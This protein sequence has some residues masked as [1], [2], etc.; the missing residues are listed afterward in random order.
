MTSQ[1]LKSLNTNTLQGFTAQR[2]H[3]WHYK[4]SEQGT[5]PN[6]YDGAIPVGD[7]LRRLFGWHAVSAP[8]Q[9]VVPATFE[10]AT[11]LDAAGNPIRTV[12]FAGK[13]GI[14]RSDTGAPLGLHSK[15]YAIH[16]YDEW[17]VNNVSTILGDTLQIGSAGLL[18]GGAKAWVQIEAP[19]T[20]ATPEG[21][22]FRPHLMA[23][24]AHDGTIATTYMTGM[25]VVVCD[26][27]RAMALAEGKR[28]GQLIRFKHSS[29]SQLRLAEARTA[30]NVVE[31][32]AD[33]FTAEVAALCA[34]PVK[35]KEW[36][37]FLDVVA[38]LPEQ[39]GRSR[40][41][42]ENKRDALN[43][44]WTNDM[45]VAPWKGTA[46]GVVQAMNTYE[47]HEKS[48]RGGTRAD[49]NMHRAITGGVAKLDVGTL[50]TLRIVQAQL[51]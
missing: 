5:E 19:E 4:A 22:D 41:M 6:H 14:V 26:N 43:R 36:Q 9:L 24:T 42:A 18:D 7:V 31:Q 44:L 49:R 2:G 27:T 15:G 37:G 32:I 35:P 40:T 45:R 21:V 28:N 12:E 20:I 39:A 30:L 3:A 34:E 16:Q 29:G 1:T 11:G 38:K 50:E 17:L 13:Q 51:A 8:V 25:T 23:T 48:V 33:D 10:D 47:H 46:Y